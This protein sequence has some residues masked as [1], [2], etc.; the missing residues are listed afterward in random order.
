MIELPL[1]MIF[2]VTTRL[3][4]IPTPPATVNAPVVAVVESVVLIID[5]IPPIV[6]A[7]VTDNVLAIVAA[8]VTANVLANVVAPVTANVLE[9]AA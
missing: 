4:P 9:S 3:P 5:T 1:I 6:V 2:L 8:P 7:P